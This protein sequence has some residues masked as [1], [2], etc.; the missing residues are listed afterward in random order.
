MIQAIL[1]HLLSLTI[2]N[3]PEVEGGARTHVATAK[4]EQTFA[5]NY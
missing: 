2:N 1:N 4:T 5:L 3:W